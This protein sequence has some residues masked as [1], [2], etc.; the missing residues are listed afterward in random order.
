MV[1]A[2]A[3]SMADRLKAWWHG[4][5]IDADDDALPPPPVAAAADYDEEPPSVKSTEWTNERVDA[6]QRIFGAGQ[7]APKA[8]D[9]A[10]RLIK[11]LGLNDTM[12]VLELGCGIGVGL[13]AVA[14]K[15]GAWIDGIENNDLLVEE[16][17]RWVGSDGVQ[18]K[19]VPMNRSP[20]DA[21]VTRT[22]RD[23]ILSREAL[24]RFGERGD[25]MKAMRE[26][27]KPR[28]QLLYTDFMI[29]PDVDQAFVDSWRELHP[30]QPALITLDEAKAE[31][32]K[33]GLDLRVAKDESDEYID[34]VVE[35][36]QKFAVD[37]KQNPVNRD[38]QPW[39]LWEVEYWARTVG[40]IYSGGLRVCRVHAVAPAGSAR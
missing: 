27:M 16:A 29:D 6:V 9:R 11:P 36:M 13:R 33:L 31:I 39:V 25:V 2:V 21:S 40:A 22:R 34:C 20:H 4:Y 23:V 7:D 15:S 35:Q 18:K 28:G 17:A 19:A 26:I 10:Q 30:Q 5:D 37:L 12:S 24:H 8:Y 38:T 1:S 14:G 3:Q 32:Q